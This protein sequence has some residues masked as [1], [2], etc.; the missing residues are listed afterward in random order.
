MLIIT[1]KTMGSCYR[2]R[3]KTSVIDCLETISEAVDGPWLPTKFSS[4]LLSANI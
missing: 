1:K 3:K 2:E 4:S